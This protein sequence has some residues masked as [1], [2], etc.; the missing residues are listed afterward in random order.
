MW[1]ARRATHFGRV[2]ARALVGALLAARRHVH[3]FRGGPRAGPDP[4]GPEG[5][6]LP[7]TRTHTCTRTALLQAYDSLSGCLAAQL[8]RA[9]LMCVVHRT[10]VHMC[11]RCAH[12]CRMI[13]ACWQRVQLCWDVLYSCGLST[14]CP[15]SATLD[16]VAAGWICC[17]HGSRGKRMLSTAASWQLPHAC[18][19]L[20]AAHVCIYDPVVNI[21]A[22]PHSF[23]RLMLPK[24]PQTCCRPCCAAVWNGAY[25]QVIPPSWQ[26]V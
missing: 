20:C 8:H 22:Q 19:A 24:M 23:D 14:P 6:P 26:E 12:A 4:E 13:M 2:L 1:C 25:W 17:D 15:S 11:M 3:A 10:K 16:P 9:H 21:F 18:C 5:L 7:P